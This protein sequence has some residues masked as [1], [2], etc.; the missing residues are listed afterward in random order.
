MIKDQKPLLT[1]CIAIPV[2]D[3]INIADN[4]PQLYRSII[5]EIGTC[6][7]LLIDWSEQS[8]LLQGDKKLAKALVML[9]GLRE[10]PKTSSAYK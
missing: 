6:F 9:L 2:N 1:R 8:N 3:V 7:R 4:T 5:N 10:P